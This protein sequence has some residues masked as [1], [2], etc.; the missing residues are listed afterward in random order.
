MRVPR[1]TDVESE[2]GAHHGVK[3]V[4]V[5]QVASW[6][7]WERPELAGKARRSSGRARARSVVD[8]PVDL[9]H[10]MGQEDVRETRLGVR[11][12]KER[13]GGAGVI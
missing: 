12:R 8:A 3:H 10:D 2:R 4:D 5:D 7:S 6:L 1:D 13:R 11:K 9:L